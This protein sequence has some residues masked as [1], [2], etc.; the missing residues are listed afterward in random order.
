MLRGCKGKCHLYGSLAFAGR[1]APEH[2]IINTRDAEN[3]MP[4]IQNAGS[5][6]LGPWAPVTVGDYAS[7]T[8]HTL[9][10]YGYARM[11]SGVSLDSFQKHMTVQVLSREGLQNIGPAV[12]IMAGV[13][14]L[15]AHRKS[16]T[17][18]LGTE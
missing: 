13:E 14:G 6:F 5:V 10:T 17:L 18:R 15:E 11:Y 8:N 12:S 4:D 7:G 16:I 2:L 1:Y 9:P 3:W